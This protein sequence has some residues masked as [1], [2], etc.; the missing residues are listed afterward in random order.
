MSERVCRLGRGPWRHKRV[1]L[2]V[3]LGHWLLDRPD[4][5]RTKVRCDKRWDGHQYS[6]CFSTSYG[7]V[8]G[9]QM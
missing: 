7:Y 2:G 5:S 9:G 1:G 8:M 3:S 4:F 6:R